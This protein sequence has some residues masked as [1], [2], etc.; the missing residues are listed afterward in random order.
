VTGGE[1]GDKM[2]FGGTE[3]ALSIVRAVVMR[4]DILYGEVLCSEVFAEGEGGLVVENKLGKGVVAGA[5]KL[6]DGL[7]SCDIR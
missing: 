2:V 4:G 7:E 3:V 5:E 1:G 6:E